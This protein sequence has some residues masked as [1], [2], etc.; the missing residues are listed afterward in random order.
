MT[1]LLLL[2]SFQLIPPAAAQTCTTL[3]QVRVASGVQFKCSKVGSKLQ[4]VRQA[5]KAVAQ[6]DQPR[7]PTARPSPSPVP[8]PKEFSPCA[9]P[10]R[11]KGAGAKQIVCVK[12]RSKMVWVR[13]AALREPHP[14]RPCERE[15]MRGDWGAE[16]L[17]C[18]Y[19]Y[20]GKVW[21]YKDQALAT[22]KFYQLVL[23]GC[24]SRLNGALD[25]RNGDSWRWAANLRFTASS[26]CT[27]GETFRVSASLN[28]EELSEVRFRLHGSTWDLRSEL[29][30]LVGVGKVLSPLNSVR[31]FKTRTAS[32]FYAPGIYRG[33]KFDALEQDLSNRRVRFNYTFRGNAGNLA[34]SIEVDGVTGL[35]ID[36]RN[37][38]VV[39]F[40]RPSVDVFQFEVDG[41]DDIESTKN[42][43]F[44]LSTNQ[45]PSNRTVT[46]TQTL[47]W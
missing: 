23:P 31:V 3:N 20:E 5:A 29:V 22:L 39:S 8:L 25:K 26:D 37:H 14:G 46:V 13:L 1:S 7:R 17:T 11:D 30:S 6:P 4:W 16:E 40:T 35:T 43:Q 15:G 34:P 36:G 28:S 18:L 41:Y 32:F 42:I 10:G 33:F 21:D 12:V 44:T 24:H 27:P 47:I 45:S 19:T 9:N 2:S 38:A